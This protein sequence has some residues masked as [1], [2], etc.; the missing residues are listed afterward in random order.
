[1]VSDLVAAFAA[2]DYRRALALHE[3]LLP[4]NQAL[5]IETNP[6][7]VKTAM[8]L[9]GLPAGALRLPLV[10]MEPENKRK[11]TDVLRRSGLL[12]QA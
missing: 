1:M 12:S 9:M 7:P 4:L 5:F 8:Q 6:I 2:G 3:Q 10:A 11:L